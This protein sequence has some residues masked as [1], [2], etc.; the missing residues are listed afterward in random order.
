MDDD[1]LPRNLGGFDGNHDDVLLLTSSRD[2]VN[3]ASSSGKGDLGRLFNGA[4]HGLVRRVRRGNVNGGSAAENINGR[5]PAT[6]AGRIVVEEDLVKRHFD[7]G[8]RDAEL[9]VIGARREEPFAVSHGSRQCRSG[10]KKGRWCERVAEQSRE[11][12]SLRLLRRS[13]I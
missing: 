12:K 6:V 1:G 11:M 2:G 8:S 10:V 9:V 5:S 13:C 7:S 4:V 3:G